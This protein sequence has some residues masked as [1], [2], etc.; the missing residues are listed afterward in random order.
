MNFAFIQ[1]SFSVNGVSVVNKS[2]TAFTARIDKSP[3]YF[4][5]FINN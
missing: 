4:L 5:C 1:T 2:D 3:V